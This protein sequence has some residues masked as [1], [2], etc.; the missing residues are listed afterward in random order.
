[1][2]PCGH[3]L[4]HDLLH[5]SLTRAFSL[6]RNGLRVEGPQSGASEPLAMSLLPRTVKQESQ[7]RSSSQLPGMIGSSHSIR[8][9][10]D[11]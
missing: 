2:H 8:L 1:M 3:T 6:F 11:C 5:C 9:S 10:S 4:T 7:G